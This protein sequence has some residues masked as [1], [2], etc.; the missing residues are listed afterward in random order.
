MQGYYAESQL[1]AHYLSGHGLDFGTAPLPDNR[2]A[3]DSFMRERKCAVQEKGGGGGAECRKYLVGTVVPS[4]EN[5]ASRP[6]C[7]GSREK[8]SLAG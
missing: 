2:M 7:I 6:T 1:R 8:C 4:V 5:A 3:I